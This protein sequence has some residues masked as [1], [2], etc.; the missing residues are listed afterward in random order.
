MN[1]TRIIIALSLLLLSISVNSQDKLPKQSNVD[2]IKHVEIISDSLEIDSV[3]VINKEDIDVINN[4]FRERDLMGK[5]LI[6]S[7]S[8]ILKMEAISLEKSLII[9]NKSLIIEADAEIRKQMEKTLK[10]RMNV[11][12]QQEKTIKK[13]KTKKKIWQSTTG[14]AIAAI[15]IIL[16]L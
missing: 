16:C 6:L 10:D 12:E 8:M 2:K 5:S 4:V 11:I 15:I 7:D 14:A 3:A 13:E 9:S 1:K